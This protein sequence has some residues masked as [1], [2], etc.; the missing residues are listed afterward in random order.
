MLT[1]AAARLAARICHLECTA[2]GAA[3]CQVQPWQ[4]THKDDGGKEWLLSRLGPCLH[5]TDATQGGLQVQRS[6]RGQAL[7]LR[8]SNLKQAANWRLMGV[9]MKQPAGNWKRATAAA[10]AAGPMQ[11]PHLEHRHAPSM[12][13]R[14]LGHPAA[15]G[16]LSVAKMTACCS[17]FHHDSQ[18]NFS[19]ACGND[20]V[21]L[22]PLWWIALPVL[23][24]CFASIALRRPCP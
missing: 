18:L 1:A 12:W 16:R 3:I 6:G 8:F 10:A 15:A 5:K 2:T 4:Y 22:C 23:L 24:S 7:R 17:V 21:A 11:C 19:T 14:R 20:S 9:L 13:R